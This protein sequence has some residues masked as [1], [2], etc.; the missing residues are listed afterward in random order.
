MLGYR[1]PIF[2]QITATAD[3]VGDRY[4]NQQNTLKGNDY[5]VFGIGYKKT[6]EK[7]DPRVSFFFDI[8]NLTN[9]QEIVYGSGSPGNESLRPIYG[10]YLIGGVE[11][12]F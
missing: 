7:W 9:E 11:F 8:K 3:Y 12:S 2:G 6:F 4:F 1:H 5:W 10:R